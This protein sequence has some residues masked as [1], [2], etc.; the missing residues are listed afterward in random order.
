MTLLPASPTPAPSQDAAPRGNG[1]PQRA[2]HS[3]MPLSAQSPPAPGLRSCGPLLPV[4]QLNGHHIPSKQGREERDV[5]IVQLI[6]RHLHGGLIHFGVHGLGG[7]GALAGLGGLGG[8]GLL[9][10]CTGLGSASPARGARRGAKAAD[11]TQSQA[12]ASELKGSDSRG[13]TLC[14]TN[15]TAASPTQTRRYF[16]SCF[17]I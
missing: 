15:S 11:W 7:R 16:G 4:I 2:A 10:R 8:C 17:F 14:V 1:D 13:V 3:E 12:D 9:A 6:D 5:E